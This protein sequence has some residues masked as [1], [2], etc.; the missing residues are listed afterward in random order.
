MA[1]LNNISEGHSTYIVHPDDI[2]WTD[3]DAENDKFN[4]VFNKPHVDFLELPSFM[5]LYLP[6]YRGSGKGL[7]HAPACLTEGTAPLRK[8]DI[9]QISI[10]HQNL[11]TEDIKFQTRFYEML[12]QDPRHQHAKMKHENTER[13]LELDF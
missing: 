6:F 11:S 9:T 7:V 3:F 4:Y 12:E 13:N 8:I 10:N 2:T 1:C 5:Q